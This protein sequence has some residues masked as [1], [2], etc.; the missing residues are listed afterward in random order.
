MSF[1]V[2]LLL[3]VVIGYLGG[4]IMRPEADRGALLS[5]AVGIVG[6]LLAAWLLAPLLG[7]S[8]GQGF[9]STTA[10]AASLLGAV[11]LVGLLN[12]VRHGRFR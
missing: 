7:G 10:V 9:Y 5:T 8:P 1:F 11:V 4:L 2:W 6:A 3:G 12:L